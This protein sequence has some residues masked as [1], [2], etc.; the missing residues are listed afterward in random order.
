MAEAV[1]RMDTRVSQ[2]T[3]REGKYL[4]FTLD[5]EEYGLEIL[6]VREIIG[7]M[8]ITSVPQTPNYVKGVVN[9]R[10]RVIPVIDL[11]LKF[12]LPATEWTERTC[13]IVVDVRGEAGVMQ[14]GIVVDAVSEVMNILGDDIEPTPS[15]GT[16][17]NT[18][19]ILGI[20]KVRGRVKILLDIDKVLTGEEIAGMETITA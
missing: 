10:G 18:Q 8:E 19:Y 20:A 1:A 9:L 3:E 17:L 14:M 7:M 5:K 11:R 4:T 13:I 12:G 16:R 2:M 6:K 15:F